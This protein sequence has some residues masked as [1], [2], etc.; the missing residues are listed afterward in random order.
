MFTAAFAVFISG[1]GVP[2]G[3]TSLATAQ[4]VPPSGAWA[5]SSHV[6]TPVQ[7]TGSAA[8]LPQLVPTEATKADVKGAK[9]VAP[10]KRPKGALPLE[11]R[12][13]VSKEPAKGGLK[14]PASKAPAL[15][16]TAST[17]AAGDCYH[18]AWGPGIPYSTGQIVS[19]FN[20]TQGMTEAHDFEATRNPQG[21][22]PLTTTAWKDLGPCYVEPT[23]P[24][25]VPPSFVWFSPGSGTL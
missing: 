9:I 3:L 17:A 23:G 11:V 5:D 7:R 6:D 19:Y 15:P 12:R 2:D 21:L 25:P 4:T 1:V 16:R 22:P 10:A 14:P 8:G 18:A 20:S 13:E 24:P